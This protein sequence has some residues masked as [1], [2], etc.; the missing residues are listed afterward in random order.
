MTGQELGLRVLDYLFLVFHTGLILFNLLG[1]I[2]PAFRKAHFFSIC[3]TFASWFLLGIWYGWGY[4]FLTDW[5]W[6][7]L[8]ALNEGPLMNSYISYLLDRFFGLRLSTELVDIVTVGFAVL[9]LIIS[10]Y[11]NFFKPKK[12]R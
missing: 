4:C 5:H 1:W 12:M 7:V 2:R 9:A 11:V 10:V 6:Q 3:L 8:V